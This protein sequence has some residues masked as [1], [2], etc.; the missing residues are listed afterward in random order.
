MTTPTQEEKDRAL[1]F[2]EEWHRERGTADPENIH[3][4]ADCHL[5]ATAE[6]ARARARQRILLDGL[7]HVRSWNDPARMLGEVEK[8]LAAYDKLARGESEETKMTELNTFDDL[9]RETGVL[10][11]VEAAAA[12]MPPPKFTPR[13]GDR[14][15]LESKHQNREAPIGSVW[16]ILEEDPEDALYCWRACR[17][18]DGFYLWFPSNAVFAPAPA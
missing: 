17:I 13:A 3:S 11:A 14:V 10:E 16:D 12:A 6:L 18:P 15:V 1:R 9:L 4:L 7:Y 2:A 5:P 8:A